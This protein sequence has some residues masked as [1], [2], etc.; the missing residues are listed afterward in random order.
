LIAFP[1][2]TDKDKKVSLATGVS[3][4]QEVNL[5]PVPNWPTVIVAFL[6]GFVAFCASA[7]IYDMFKVHSSGTLPWDKIQRESGRRRFWTYVGIRVTVGI[8]CGFL[9]AAIALMPLLGVIAAGVVPLTVLKILTGGTGDWNDDAEGGKPEKQNPARQQKPE[10]Q[11][12]TGQEGK[13][14]PNA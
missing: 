10:K 5:W 6:I 13:D 3:F 2:S 7:V 11:D 4:W 12:P 8:C 1:K 9:A 14:D